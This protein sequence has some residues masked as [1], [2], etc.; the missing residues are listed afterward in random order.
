MAVRG[1]SDPP[2]AT[3]RQP[4]AE[5]DAG[6]GPR[7]QTCIQRQCSA[8]NEPQKA[9]ILRYSTDTSQRSEPWQT[10]RNDVF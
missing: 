8:P 6:S 9:G 10:F 4:L 5:P 2:A 7:Q 3:R 1:D